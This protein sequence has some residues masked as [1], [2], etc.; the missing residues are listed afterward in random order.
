MEDKHIINVIEGTPV[1]S[2]SEDE[3]TTINEHVHECDDCRK[4]FAAANISAVLLRERAT[5]ADAFE[6]PPFFHTRMFAKLRERQAGASDFW[7]LGR[8]WRAAGALASTMVATV[9][10]L[11]VLTFLAPGTQSTAGVST[12]A[13]ARN[14]Y[15]AEEMIFNQGGLPDDQ[16]SDGQVLTALYGAED[17]AVR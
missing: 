6:P 2:L 7:A 14:N 13:T 5:E 12:N 17:D 4:A 3:L 11:A 9:A 15:S 16:I 8:M 10:A 1:A